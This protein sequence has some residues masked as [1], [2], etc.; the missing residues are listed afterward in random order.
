MLTSGEV[1]TGSSLTS[2]GVLTV[3][4]CVEAIQYIQQ[5]I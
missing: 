5:E 4:P 1:Q 2:A 3:L